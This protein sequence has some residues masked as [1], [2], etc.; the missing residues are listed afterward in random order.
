MSGMQQHAWR[1]SL[2]R[3]DAN[4]RAVFERDGLLVTGLGVV[5]QQVVHPR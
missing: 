5:S 3:F 4:G 1:A 2:L